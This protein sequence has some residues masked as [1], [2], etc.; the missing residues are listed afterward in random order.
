[1]PWGLTLEQA[2]RLTECLF[3]LSLLIQTVEFLRLRAATDEHGLWSWSLQRRDIP[4]AMWRRMLDVLF[5]PWV[6]QLHLWMRL[7]AALALIVQGGSLGL[8]VFLF[9]GNVLILIRW[10]G[11]FNGGS[12]F[13][14]LAVLTGLLVAYAVAAWGDTGLGMKAGLWYIG[15]QSVTSYFMSGAVK[16]LQP[17]WRSGRA[18]TIFLNAAIYGPLP[19]RHPLRRPRWAQLGSWIFILWECLFPLALIN[20]TWAFAMCAVAVLFHF[21]VFWFFGLNRFFWA[22]VASFP[23]IIWCAGQRLGG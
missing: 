6:H 14:T 22:W 16:I 9:L 13:L 12:D 4:S 7:V 2:L 18:M 20:A 8:M 3:A 5:T 21:L 23:A 19:A 17:E 1:M 10:R 11:A 15:I